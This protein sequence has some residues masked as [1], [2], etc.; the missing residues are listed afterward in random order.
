MLTPYIE[1]EIAPFHFTLAEVPMEEFHSFN[2]RSRRPYA[3]VLPSLSQ[4]VWSNPRA[5][6]KR[7]PG[8]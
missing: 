2:F 6:V 3:A 7:R 5:E 8:G 4:C 1:A